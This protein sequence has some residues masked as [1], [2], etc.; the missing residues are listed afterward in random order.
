MKNASIVQLSFAI[1]SEVLGTTFM[2]LS[3]GFTHP[4]FG[5]VTVVCYVTSFVLLTLALKHLSLGMAYGIWGG[6]G[7]LLTTL[8]G[9]AVW[10]DPFSVV[11]GI[12]MI[13][14]VA[15]IA[16]LSKGTQEA[17]EAAA[18]EAAEATA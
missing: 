14:V 6:V 5:L 4:V 18:A 2:K 7:T 1:V 10:N 16:L 13:A 15:G 9:I 8:V 3:D 12:G 11:V 17:E